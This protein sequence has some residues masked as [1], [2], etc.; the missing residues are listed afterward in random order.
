MI[1]NNPDSFTTYPNGRICAILSTG[2][3]AEDVLNAL[4]ESGIVQEDIEVYCGRK[5]AIV[6]DV[7]ADHHGLL[8][9]IAKVFRAFGDME[10][11][12]MQKYK[13][14]LEKGEYVF[15][16]LVKKDEEKETIRRILAKHE[17]REIQYFGTWVVESLKV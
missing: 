13:A 3:A 6:M 15:A 10:N 11:K 1:V 5:G 2:V 7:D 4:L 17:A 8:A 9:K 16:I 14:A 12:S